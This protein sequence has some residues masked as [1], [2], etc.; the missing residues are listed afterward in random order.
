MTWSV[1]YWWSS[2][3]CFHIY[4]LQITFGTTNKNN[5]LSHQTL[6]FTIK[7]HLRNGRFTSLI[8]GKNQSI[9]TVTM[10]CICKD[11]YPTSFIVWSTTFP[12]IIFKSHYTLW[13][14]IISFLHSMLLY[15]YWCHGVYIFMYITVCLYILSLLS[16][17]G[18]SEYNRV[19][20][21][22]PS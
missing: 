19:F 15:F 22:I 21:I 16:I 13:T 11:V 3:Q 9:H 12:F 18:S 6:F 5:Y 17:C 7:Q 20:S 4:F 10:Y 1:K 14:T 8:Y 2:E